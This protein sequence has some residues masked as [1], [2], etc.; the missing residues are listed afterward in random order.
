MG[1]CKKVK[2]SGERENGRRCQGGDCIYIGIAFL[3]LKFHTHKKKKKKNQEI[4]I[5]RWK[6]V[7]SSLFPVHLCAIFLNNRN[8]YIIIFIKKSEQKTCGV[9]SGRYFLGFWD[10]GAFYCNYLGFEFHGRRHLRLKFFV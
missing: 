1:F 2:K 5:R 6:D 10:S 8:K 7:G 3:P 4:F 9:E